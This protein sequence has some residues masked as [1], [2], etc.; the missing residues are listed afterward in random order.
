MPVRCHGLHILPTQ[1]MNSTPGIVVSKPE[2]GTAK[3]S[4]SCRG[5][6][7]AIELTYGA[8]DNLLSRLKRREPPK[9][10]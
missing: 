7:D 4:L 1:G 9:E 6:A 8:K 2:F 10:T 3:V 5:F